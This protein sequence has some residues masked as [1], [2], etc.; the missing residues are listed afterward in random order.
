[1]FYFNDMQLTNSS[2]IVATST[3]WLSD[4]F[5]AVFVGTAISAVD[6]A[7]RSSLECCVSEI[8][9]MAPKGM[10]NLTARISALEGLT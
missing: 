4:D 3:E 7:T 5:P 9:L 10:F 1:M 2:S 8:V 6:S